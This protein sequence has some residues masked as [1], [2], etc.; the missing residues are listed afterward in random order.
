VLGGQRHFSI[1]F[2][3][4]YIVGTQKD[5]IGNVIRTRKISLPEWAGL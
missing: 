5:A 2:T 1:H 4:G 3:A